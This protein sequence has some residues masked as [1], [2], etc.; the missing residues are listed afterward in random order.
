MLSASNTTDRWELVGT[1][2]HVP[3]GA[4]SVTYHFV[5]TRES[6]GTDDSYLDAAFVYVLANTLATDIGA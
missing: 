1:R 5:G 3:V 4:R 6:G 2:V